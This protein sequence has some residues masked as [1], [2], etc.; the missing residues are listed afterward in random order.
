MELIIEEIE[1]LVSCEKC[2]CIYRFLDQM[3]DDAPVCPAC[4]SSQWQLKQGREVMIKEIGVVD[5]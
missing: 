2:G 4:Q 5:E 3:Q 1:G